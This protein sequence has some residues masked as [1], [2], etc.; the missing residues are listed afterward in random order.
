[1]PETTLQGRTAPRPELAHNAHGVGRE[2]FASFRSVASDAETGA[3]S[4]FGSE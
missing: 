4:L 2:L 3:V 1:V